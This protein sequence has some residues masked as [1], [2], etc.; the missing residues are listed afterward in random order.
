MAKNVIEG[1][2]QHCFSRSV[3]RANWGRFVTRKHQGAA[4]LL[5]GGTA[6]RGAPTDGLGIDS[7]DAIAR[8]SFLTV[9]LASAWYPDSQEY[10]KSFGWG[11]SL[12]SC[13]CWG[14]RLVMTESASHPWI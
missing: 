5:V 13:A 12:H 10:T 7:S 2:D 8:P 4:I 9:S 14:W 11:R 6:A 1:E 3:S